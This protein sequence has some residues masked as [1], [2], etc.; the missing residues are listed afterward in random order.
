MAELFE[1]FMIL[2]FGFSWP[3]SIIKTLKAKTAAGKSP[4]FISLIIIGYIFGIVSKIISGNIN[5]AF[6]FYWINL[7]MTSLDLVI[8]LY[9]RKKD[10]L[11]NGEL[12]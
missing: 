7:A 1:I 5:L 9:Y 6:I 11:I 10:T 3:I 8:Q 2:C 4:V 12:K